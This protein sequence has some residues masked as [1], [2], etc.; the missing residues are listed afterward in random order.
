MSPQ[1]GMLVPA[2]E[3][4]PSSAGLPARALNEGSCPWLVWSC[5]RTS[6]PWASRSRRFCSVC[7]RANCTGWECF[8][9]KRGERISSWSSLPK[10]EEDLGDRSTRKSATMEP[11]TSGGAA[12][13]CSRGRAEK[14]RPTTD[15]S[16]QTC[17]RFANSSQ[18]CQ[19]FVSVWHRILQANSHFAAFSRSTKSSITN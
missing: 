5:S 4:Y 12:A 17:Q 13:G 10:K 2:I 8:D 1:I 3:K 11:S 18:T 6:S 16:A 14:A 19:H 7:A 9:E 15:A